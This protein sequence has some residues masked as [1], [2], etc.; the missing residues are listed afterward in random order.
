ML[1]SSAPV[2][3][4]VIPVFN[5]E[6][7][8]GLQIYGNNFGPLRDFGGP[9]DFIRVSQTTTS[10]QQPMG[11]SCGAVSI[12]DHSQLVCS[13]ANQLPAVGT[14]RVVIAIGGQTDEFVFCKC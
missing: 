11:V 6:S 10:R 12:L 14:Y 1:F 3:T 2:I 13:L 9:N 5:S 7:I 8:A 4:S